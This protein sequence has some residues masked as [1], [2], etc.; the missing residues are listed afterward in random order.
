MHHALARCLPAVQATHGAAYSRSLSAMPPPHDRAGAGCPSTSLGA[1]APFAQIDFNGGH[2]N[3]LWEYFV[4]HNEGPILHKW[5]VT[6]QLT[7]ILHM[8]RHSAPP[9]S[10]PEPHTEQCAAA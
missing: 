3:P 2:T 9:H 1:P 5:Y 10:Q 7:A 8:L 6:P 4:G